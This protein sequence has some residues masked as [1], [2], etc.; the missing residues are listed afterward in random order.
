MGVLRLGYVEVRVKDVPA[1]VQY[2]TRVLGIKETGRN[3]GK[4]YL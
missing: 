4:V 2:Y 3:N 1:A